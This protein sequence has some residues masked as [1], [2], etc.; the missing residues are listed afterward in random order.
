[1]QPEKENYQKVIAMLAGL[2]NKCELQSTQIQQY[3][4]S[5]DEI[6]LTESQYLSSS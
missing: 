2:E 4:E 5:S 1:M 3:I 6:K